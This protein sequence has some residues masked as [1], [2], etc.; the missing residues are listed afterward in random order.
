MKARKNPSAGPS[1]AL[2]PAIL[3]IT[4]TV[5]VYWPA[6]TGGFIF[7]DDTLLTK[8]PLIHA[9]DGLSRMWFTTE[10]LDYWPMTTTSFWL[11]WR[12]WGLDSTP[13]HVT[14]LIL[15]LGSS[16]ML[17]AILRRLSIPGAWLAAMLFAIHPVNVESVAWIAQR[18]NTLSMLFFLLAIFWYLDD[19]FVSVWPKHPVAPGGQ[20]PGTATSRRRD[21]LAAGSRPSRPRVTRTYWLSLL[22]FVLAMLS[23]GSVAVLPALLLL[24][25]WWRRGEVS[26]ADLIRTSPFFVVAAL[27]TLVNIWFQSHYMSGE[28]IRHVTLVQR[29]LGAA[30][31][32]WFYLSKALLPIRLIFIYPQWD[33]RSVDV[34]W[35]LP[36]TAAA[37]V[38]AVLVWQRRR[39]VVRA[40]LFAWMAFGLAL[41]PV[42]G[43]TDVYFMKFALVADH[44][45]YIAIIAVVACVAAA[46]WRLPLAASARRI[47]AAALIVVLGIATWQQSELYADAE[48]LYRATLSSN[49]STWLVHNDL[50]VLIA[51]RSPGEAIEHFRESL[52]LNPDN[53]ESYN[54]LCHALAHAG[55]MSETI[56][57]CSSALRRDPSLYTAHNDLGAAMASMGKLDQARAEFEAALRL[58]PAYDEAHNNLANVLA[59]TGRVA[60]AIDH[61]RAAL[62]ATPEFAIGHLNLGL[63]LEREGRI[64]EAIAEYKEAARLDP[65]LSQAQQRLA[66]LA[67]GAGRGGS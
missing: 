61:Y 40:L 45:Q 64:S 47:A 5:L 41:V 51:S 27:L 12:L 53:V 3:L 1:Q 59:A 65:A 42:M 4:A 2:I 26:R 8:N 46:L 30:A 49:P 66:V 34:R 10:P 35:W 25:V 33:I 44:Y 60:E 11:E 43:F 29:A 16:L 37:A 14:N 6:L 54:N 31:V 50:G 24:M 56:V 48:T 22:A 9:A 67:H 18:K 52:R 19:E 28:A 20:R 36:L 13:Y 57:A 32:A 38:T 7:D 62:L 39:P 21:A 58:A 17:W 63:A 55:R 15:H 23:K